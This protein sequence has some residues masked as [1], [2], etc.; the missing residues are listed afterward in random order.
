MSR[1]TTVNSNYFEASNLNGTVV[2]GNKNDH[3][4]NI[5]SVFNQTNPGV[6]EKVKQTFP[7]LSETEYKIV[8][9]TY[10]R[11]SVRD[12]SV[13]LCIS[14]NTVQTYRTVLRKKLGIDD[15]TLDTAIYLKEVLDK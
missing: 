1:L 15:L 8:L 9:L 2:K 14:P 11:M 6:S 3:W 12:I 5:F 10:A 13:V 7:S 4:Q